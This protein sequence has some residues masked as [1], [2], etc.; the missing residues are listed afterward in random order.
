[1][2]RG[3]DIGLAGRAARLTEVK[4]GEL[5]LRSQAAGCQWMLVMNHEGSD[6]AAIKCRLEDGSDNNVALCA[7]A[8]CN[9][10]VLWVQPGS[11]GS[12]FDG[13]WELDLLH[14]QKFPIVC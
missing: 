13:Y 8:V 4:A 2:Q 3:L 10:S 9:V 7:C 1:M 14:D 12:G 6:D 11:H 5:A